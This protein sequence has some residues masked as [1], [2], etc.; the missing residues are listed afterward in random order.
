MSVQVAKG[1]FSSLEQS[2]RSEVEGDVY[3]DPFTRGRYAT[4]AS[5]YQINP[6]GIVVPKSIQDVKAAISLTSEEGFSL[7]PRGGGT[8]QCGQT[9]NSSVV[10]DTS[11]YLNSLIDL[12]V[13]ELTVTVEPGIVLDQLNNLLKPFGVW[14]PVDISTS[15]QATIGG[16]VGNNSCGARSIKYGTMRENVMEIKAVLPDG[17]E[18]WFGPGDRINK[19]GLSANL[20]DSLLRL[21]EKYRVAIKQNFPKVMRRV[22]GYNLDAL[23]KE[24][25]CS[26]NFSH[27][28]VGSEGTLAFSSSIKLKLASL[29]KHSTLGV[30][31]FAEFDHAMRA[32]ESIVSL[33]PTAVEL[34]DET[35]INLAAKIPTFRRVVDDVIVGNPKSVL[36]VEFAGDVEAE[37][38]KKLDCLT[39]LMGDLGYPGVVASVTEGKSQQAVWSVRKQ[40]LNIV[41][42]MKGDGKP[43]SFVEDCAVELSDLPE[44][45]RRLTEIFRKHGTTGT[46]YA[47]ASVGTL[48]V[49]PI[50]NLKL[51]SEVKKMREI[52]EETF[53]MVKEYK[54]SHSGEHGDGIVRSEFHEKMFGKEIISG[55]QELKGVLDPNNVMNP[56]RIVWPPAMDNRKL[57][58]YDASYKIKNPGTR[59]DW[60]SWGGLGGAVEM[61]NNN[62][63]CRKLSGGVMCPSFRATRDEEHSTR[64]RANTLRLAMSGKFGEDAL[65]DVGVQDSLK[66]CL[67]CKACGSECPTG[68]DMARMKIEVLA[69]K[70]LSERPAF[71]DQVIAYFPRYAPVVSR[72]WFLANQGKKIPGI[73]KMGEWLFGLDAKQD[74]PR[75][76]SPKSVNRFR[77]RQNSLSTPSVV[78]FADCFNTYFEP[79]NVHA[80]MEVLKAGG[81]SFNLLSQKGGNQRPL[82]CGRTFLSMGLVDQAMAEARRFVVSASK[83]IELGIPI[84]GLEPSCIL[85]LREEMGDLL[86]ISAEFKS[87]ILLIEEYLEKTKDENKTKLNFKSPANRKVFLHGHCHQKAAGVMSHTIGSLAQVPGVEVEVIKSGCCGMAGS[88]GYQ[89]KSSH[90][91]DKI[92]ELELAPAIRSID[93]DCAIS[94]GGTSC[95]HQI[96]NKTGR[97]A[98]HPI[99]FIRDSLADL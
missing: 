9:V 30:C 37:N 78:I 98:V 27:V 77:G 14:F 93:Q 38:E 68:V 50:L 66:Y 5:I 92:A 80:A 36:L 89:K 74:L 28:L 17:T 33:G 39:E 35:M 19:D 20:K 91:A 25:G 96:K 42:S 49:R 26:P 12:N 63:A 60:E 70:Y 3:F 72:L 32:T 56:G 18:S 34:I 59:F 81:H 46:W 61:C 44:Y 43:I 11:K 90:V 55:F 97:N 8:S 52:A 1:D 51:D 67:G 40:A 86:S 87:R 88:F 16:M 95:R 58:R 47:H 83:Y 73:S 10:I 84:V 7:L 13:E 82:C 85:S 54:G 15:A 21:G 57:L 4:D 48:H 29:P 64:G 23:M 31:H 6:V 22:G 53:D 79:D 45:T 71:H 76:A 99:R 2:I 62:G 75:W 94:A 24:E 69:Q 41:M 65:C